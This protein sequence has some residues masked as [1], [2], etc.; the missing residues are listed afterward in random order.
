MTV[1]ETV[2]YH[3]LL[4]DVLNGSRASAVDGALERSGLRER[5]DDTV[6]A[7]APGE[8]RRLCLAQALVSRP[9][10]LLID[11]AFADL[12]AAARDQLAA[13]LRLLV[14]DGVTVVV[15]SSDLPATAVTHIAIMSEGRIVRVADASS[16]VA[17]QMLDVPVTTPAAARRMAGMRVAESGE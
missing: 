16:M 10:V 11:D 3:A 4:R 8:S 9:R 5:A 2:E 14:A 7:L 6:S 13:V 17:V 12:D 15:A 1:R